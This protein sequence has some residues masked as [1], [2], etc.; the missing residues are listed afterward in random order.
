VSDQDLARL[1]HAYGAAL[2]GGG[3]P[4]DAAVMYSRC[5]ILFP[6]S[7]Y[8]A[9]SLIET[10]VVY[11]Q[12]YQRPETARRLFER[13]RGL[14]AALGKEDLVERARRALESMVSAGQP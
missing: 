5:A 7:P 10:A 13:G 11:Q 2:A 9:A 1:V 4:A 3:R 12:F 6:D 14:A 8:A